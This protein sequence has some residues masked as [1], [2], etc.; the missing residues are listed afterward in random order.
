[1]LLNKAPAGATA[2]T[3]AAQVTFAVGADPL[4]VAVGD[5]NG[6]G[7]PDFVTVNNGAGTVSVLLNTAAAGATA[8]TFAPQATFAVGG[9][10][11]S[12]AVADFN[13]DGRPDLAVVNS[14]DNTASVLLNKAPAGATAPSFA[15]QVTFAVGAN[16]LSVA[17]GDFNGD[18]RPDLVTANFN[19]ATVSVLLDTTAAGATAPSF[20]AQATFAVGTNPFFVAAAD[21]N[22][23][24]RPDLVTANEGVNTASVLLNAST[25]FAVTGAVLVAD[26]HGLGVVEYNRLTGQWVQLNPGNPSDVSLLA[27]DALGDV[28]ADFPGYGVYR[29]TPSLGS[30]QMVDGVDAVAIATDARGDL[31]ASFTGAG[32]GLFRLDGSAQ[33]LTPVAAAL[34]SSDANGDLVADFTGYGVQRRSAFS[35]MWVQVNG[36]DAEAVAIDGAGDVFASFNGAGIGEFRLDGSSRLLTSSAA[37]VLAADAGGD[38]TAPIPGFGVEEFRSGFGNRALAPAVAASLLAL[39]D[40]GFTFAEF[41][42]Y[43]LWEF[44]PLTGWRQISASDVSLLAAP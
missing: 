6:D 19:V 16:P 44:D 9:A 41:T 4:S 12:V 33:L 21:F 24:G 39:D 11:F 1:M 10:P 2:P 31:F 29:Y 36:V 35:G 32:V 7:R 37:P 40:N 28:F 27:V 26:Q 34:L 25:P 22:G 14:A 42:G 17:A 5:F 43:G 15:A 30:F 8:P 13:G 3:F 20:A 23:D 38:L 18:G